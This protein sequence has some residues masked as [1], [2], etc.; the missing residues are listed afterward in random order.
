[1]IWL[2]QESDFLLPMI[3]YKKNGINYRRNCSVFKQN[4][5]AVF[6]IQDLLDGKVNNF[7]FAASLA[8]KRF[9]N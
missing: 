4:L 2:R 1:M 7:I 5:E 9:S 3:K 6:P 8:N